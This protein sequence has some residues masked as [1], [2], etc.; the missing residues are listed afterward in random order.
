MGGPSSPPNPA[1]IAERSADR[2]TVAQLLRLAVLPEHRRN[3]LARAL[4]HAVWDFARADPA[5]EALC[6]HTNLRVRGAEEFW[7]SLP[8]QEIC[9]ARSGADSESDPRFET[10]HFEL[11]LPGM[12]QPRIP[13]K[14]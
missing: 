6:L 7:R 8:V 1:W 9:D 5:T 3:G 14:D 10:I 11:P 2:D 4:V 12:A 13:V